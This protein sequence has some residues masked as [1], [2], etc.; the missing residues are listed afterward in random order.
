MNRASIGFLIVGIC[1]LACVT[2]LSPNAIAKSTKPASQASTAD[3]QAASDLEID[4]MKKNLR[5]QKKHGRP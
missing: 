4:L 3:F 2:I 1:L 5:S